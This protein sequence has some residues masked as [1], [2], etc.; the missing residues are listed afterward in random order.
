MTQEYKTATKLV[1]LGRDPVRDQGSVNP[2]VHRTSTVLFKNYDEFAAYDRGE[3]QH[4]GYGRYGTPT[5]DA[6]ADSLAELEGA[7]HALIFASGLAAVTTSMLAFL[8]AGD[9]VLIPDCVYSST[10]K[11]TD[12]E[13]PRLG[14]EVT[15]YDPTIGAGIE[16]LFKPNTK[17]V[18]CESPG[19]LTFE[20]QDIPAIA[21]IAHAKGAVV[22]SDNTWATM[23]HQDPFALGIDISI[24]SATKY[25]AGH[26]DLVMGAVMC[27]KQHFKTLKRMHHNLGACASG[28]A[29]YLALRGL[30]TMALRLNQHEKN[31]MEVGAWLE[32]RPEVKRVLFPALP[33]HP[34]HALYKRDLRG[35]CGLFGVELG[36]VPQAALA[37]M[38]DGLH[39]FGIGFSWGGYESLIIAYQPSKIRTATNW[40]NDSTVLRLHIGLEDVGDIIADLEA[41]FVRLNAA[42]AK[43]A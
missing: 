26:S 11:F 12:Y 4:R 27:K 6:L 42:L 24:H 29:C 37:A 33:S 17:V 20:M 1:S 9:H 13:L 5:H 7:D 8:G 15:Y 3:M 38:I 23:L 41:G 10:R 25:V 31:A 2:P 22:L 28:D 16:A 21:N 36:V 19:S 43:A 14:I 32:K 40:E 34:Q 35:S 30:R 39:H 18:Y